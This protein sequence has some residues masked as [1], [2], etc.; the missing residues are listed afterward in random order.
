MLYYLEDDGRDDCDDLP[1]WALVQTRAGEPPSGQ[2]LAGLFE[3]LLSLDPSGNEGADIV[4]LL[5]GPWM[6]QADPPPGDDVA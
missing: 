5:P 6:K 2:V 3:D 4:P 1:A